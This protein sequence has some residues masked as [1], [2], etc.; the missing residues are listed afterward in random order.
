VSCPIGA[1]TC[2]C[3]E[4]SKEGLCDWPY[5]AGLDLEENR[6]ITASKKE[7]VE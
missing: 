3:A 6:E 1:E 5:R 4:Y 7:A 2:P